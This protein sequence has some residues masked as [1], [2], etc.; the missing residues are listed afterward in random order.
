MQEFAS[1]TDRKVLEYVSETPEN[2]SASGAALR[3]YSS[4]LASDAIVNSGQA[5]AHHHGCRPDVTARQLHVR[6]QCLSEQSAHRAFARTK[7][8]SRGHVYV[9]QP[10]PN[11]G[12]ARRVTGSG[13]V[14][15]GHTAVQ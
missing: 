10:L 9:V 14:I 8:H 5:P 15:S 12:A 13:D 6:T 4:I 11:D 3:I 2:A 1:V 7:I